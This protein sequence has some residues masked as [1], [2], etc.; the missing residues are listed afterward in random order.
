MEVGVGDRDQ[1]AEM[2]D[3]LT[4][5]YRSAD[6]LR[7]REIPAEDLELADDVLVGSSSHP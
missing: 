1:R 6:G 5:R 3:H 4:P 2:E 7:V